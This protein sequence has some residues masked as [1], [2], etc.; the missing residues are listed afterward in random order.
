MKEKIILFVNNNIED[1]IV[2]EMN[3]IVHMSES[4]AQVAMCTFDILMYI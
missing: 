1:D 4:C 2:L 3:M